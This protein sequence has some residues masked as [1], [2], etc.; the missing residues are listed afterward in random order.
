MRKKLLLTII[1]VALLGMP[2]WKAFSDDVEEPGHEPPAMTQQQLVGL[3][4]LDFDFYID[5]VRSLGLLVFA[6]P[7]NTLDGLGDGPFDPNELPTLAVGH[8]PTL[9]GNG[10][11]L[12]LNGLDA[13]SCNECHS[14]VSNEHEPPESGFGGVGGIAQSAFPATGLLDITDSFDDRIQYV[15]AHDPDLSLVRDGVADFNGRMI[16]PPFLFGGGGV[17]LIAKEMTQDLQAILANARNGNPGEVWSLT[18]HGVDFGY[19]VSLGQQNVEMH[20][21]GIGLDD[22]ELTEEEQLVVRPFGRKGDAF[23]MRDFDRG[24][25]QFHFGIQPTEVVGF[26][27]D[28]DGDGVVNEVVDSEMSMLHIFSVTN[29]P[30]YM[31]Y[32]D[33]ADE[34]RGFDLFR[35][36]LGC[37][38]CHRSEI[39]TE[40]QDLP[41]AFPEDPTDPWNGDVYVEIPLTQF[42]FAPDP[43]GSGI[44]VP[45]FSDLKRHDMGPGLTETCE[46]C[47]AVAN[48]EFITARLWGLEDTAPYLHDGRATT[49]YQAIMLHGGDAQYA[50]DNFAALD[51]DDQEDLIEFLEELRTPDDPNHD[52]D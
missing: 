51:E 28:E 23:S 20:L 5:D 48:E 18:T 38:D 41:L 4:N 19:L 37:N 9:Q 1:I 36:T 17:E 16:N 44:I 15:A 11:F 49:V 34:R 24:A 30:P 21:D 26:D 3:L 47:K 33:D 10:V 43:T 8:R 31:E 6:T 35:Y 52:I 46:A 7:F 2:A 39:R 14:I 13:Q 27:V 25:M 32:L 12:R 40:H 22:P 42:G 50:R 29:P 45:L